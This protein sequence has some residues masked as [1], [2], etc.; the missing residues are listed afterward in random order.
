[1]PLVQINAVKDTPVAEQRNDALDSAL[2]QCASDTPIT[3]LIH[4]FKFSPFDDLRSPHNHI[5]SLTPRQ[6]CWKALSWPRALGFG[7]T[8]SQEG[9]CIA[10]GWDASGSIWKAYGEAARA[11]RVLA[12]L[13]HRLPA[14]RPVDIVAHSLGARVALAALPHLPMAAI[15]RAVLMTPAEL[16]TRAEQALDTPAGR[17]VAVLSVSSRENDFYDFL[18]EWAVAAHRPGDR[19]L[20]H[21]LRSQRPNWLDVQIDHPQTLRALRALGFDIADPSRK[22]CHWSPYLRPGIFSLYSAFLEGRLNPDQLR[23][24]LPAQM[25]PRWSRLI[26][27]PKPIRPLPFFGK[28]PS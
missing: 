25:C 19:S 23:Q 8:P 20:S 13:I 11:G 1:M 22:V 6:E 26:S 18:L 28:A 4:G 2:S 3:I 14:N 15:R 16:A 9:L 21:G 17:T 12:S 27:L 24:R 5:L 7:A 10:F